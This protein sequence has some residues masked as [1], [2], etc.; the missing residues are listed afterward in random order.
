[1]AEKGFFN[2]S[3]HGFSIN[4]DTIT[5]TTKNEGDSVNQIKTFN[6]LGCLGDPQQKCGWASYFDATNLVSIAQL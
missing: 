6:K 4:S 2:I 5:R 1:V 3:G